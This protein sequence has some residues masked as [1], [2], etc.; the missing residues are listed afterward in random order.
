MNEV[1][2]TLA[3]MLMF[4][5]IIAVVFPLFG[6]DATGD[7]GQVFGM[8]ND[9]GELLGKMLFPAGFAALA[10]WFMKL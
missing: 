3:L 5:G 6:N 2:K 4:T 10:Y 7:L 9:I 8:Y 1:G